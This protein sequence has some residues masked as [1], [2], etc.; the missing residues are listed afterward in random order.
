MILCAHHCSCITPHWFSIPISYYYTIRP[1]ML[2]SISEMISSKGL[3][4]ENVVTEM[5]MG[6]GGRRNF[7]VNID[8]TSSSLSDKKN[9]TA[10]VRD[11]STLKAELGLDILDIRVH[12]EWYGYG[13]SFS[14][15]EGLVLTLI[16][17][18]FYWRKHRVFL[19]QHLISLG[20]RGLDI[21]ASFWFLILLLFS[22]SFLY[23]TLESLLY[24]A[25]Y[26]KEL[27]S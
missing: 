13:T 15:E 26:W 22:V 2:A 24:L 19:N 6:K 20:W 25:R 10:L 16:F 21:I 12:T 9:L 5:R 18:G 14:Q 27:I 4:I 7:C 11:L 1:G 8:C 17:R 23:Y 3:S